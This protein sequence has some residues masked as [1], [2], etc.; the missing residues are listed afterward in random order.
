MCVFFSFILLLLLLLFFVMINFKFIKTCDF[1]LVYSSTSEKFFH[2]LIKHCVEQFF[3]CCCCLFQSMIYFLFVVNV[4]ACAC[5][6]LPSVDECFYE[7]LS[8]N[9]YKKRYAKSA[10]FE[11]CM[12]VCCVVEPYWNKF[13]FS[14]PHQC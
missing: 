8:V 12:T 4:C 2:F 11:M 14:P 6:P 5:V 10:P 9:D 13:S 1:F 7:L 3:A